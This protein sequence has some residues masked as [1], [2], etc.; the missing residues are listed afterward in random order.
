MRQRYPD[1]QDFVHVQFTADEIKYKQAS[2]RKAQTLLSQKALDQLLADGDYTEF[3]GRLDKLSKDNNLLWRLVPSSGDTAVL[4]HSNL[5]TPAFCTQM[6]N[7][8]YGDRPSAKRLQTFSQYLKANDLPD[9]WPFA[10]YFLF[11]C[12]PNSNILVKPRTARW[13][14][15]FMWADEYDTAELKTKVLITMQPSAGSYAALLA[16]SYHLREALEPFGVRDM[17]DVQSFVWVC[18]QESR[19]NIEGLNAKGQ[20]ELD[21]PESLPDAP[22]SYNVAEPTAVLRESEEPPLAPTM[23]LADITAETGWPEDTLRQW[24]QAMLRKGQTI[25]YGPPGTGKTYMAR[26]LAQY[27]TGRGNGF[28][29]LVQFHPAYS[30]ETFVQG[31]RP[32][33]DENGRLHYEMVHG[34]FLRFCAR[35]RQ[36]PGL[37]I[38]IIDE[39]NRANLASVLGEL[40]YLLEYRDA[41]IELAEHGRF[42]IPPNVMIIGTMNTADRSIALVDYALRRRF[43]FLHLPPNDD[44]LRSYHA[45]TDVNP[46]PLLKLLHRLNR[47]IGDPHY[48]LGVTFFM[49]P[50]LPSQI[51]A[52]WRTEIEPYLEEYFFDQPDL[53]ASFRWD[54]VGRQLQL[55][56]DT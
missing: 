47:Q 9:K 15:K 8:L 46:E 4:Y 13:F 33:T 21:V 54:K 12:H 17:V 53:V 14:L 41:E 22:V 16:Q 38:L 23:T 3:I 31:L 20:V 49:Q 48:Y 52:I 24:L 34:R 37:C 44:T 7:L 25:F 11:L 39:I 30:Y 28:W 32:F 56:T 5:D 26:K 19:Q 29:E 35:A 18:A 10:T 42:R 27:L 40:M 36:Y 50:D 1:W 6:R 2:I 55:A 45:G 43:A 51:K